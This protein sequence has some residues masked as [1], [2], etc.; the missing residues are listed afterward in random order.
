LLSCGDVHVVAGPTPMPLSLATV[1]GGVG[2]ADAEEP[3][4]GLSVQQVALESMDVDQSGCPRAVFVEAARAHHVPV[5][6]WL[7]RWSASMPVTLFLERRA[8]PSVAGHGCAR[9]SGRERIGRP[10]DAVEHISSTLLPL[11]CARPTT[12]ARAFAR[13]SDSDRRHAFAGG[14]FNN[15]CVPG[16]RF[17]GTAMRPSDVARI[18]STVVRPPDQARLAC[19]SAT[20]DGRARAF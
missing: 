1:G 4:A 19:G 16:D 6:R 11:G 18:V 14:P 9:T 17:H 8:T 5:D 13:G 15:F 20:P 3:T 7:F 10:L 12:R 2:H